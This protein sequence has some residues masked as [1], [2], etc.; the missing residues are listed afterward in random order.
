MAVSSRAGPGLL[1]IWGATPGAAG[2]GSFPLG[3]TW[4]CGRAGSREN[5]GVGGDIGGAP[6]GAPETPREF[7]RVPG[8]AEEGAGSDPFPPLRLRCT[9][10]MD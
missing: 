9:R 10:R 3:D 1:F 7:F 6:G 8:A 2:P 5:F 4:R